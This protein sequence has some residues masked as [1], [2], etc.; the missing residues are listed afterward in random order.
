MPNGNATGFCGVAATSALPG[1][2]RVRP[3]TVGYDKRS[4]GITILSYRFHCS[5]VPA[6]RLPYPAHRTRNDRLVARSSYRAAVRVS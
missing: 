5:G 1:T 3:S 2:G 4:A 6:L